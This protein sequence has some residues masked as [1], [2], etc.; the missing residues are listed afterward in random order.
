MVVRI[1]FAKGPSL[2]RRRADR[3][4]VAGAAGAL[5]TPAALVASV[6]AA[7][8]IAADLNV[9]DR[10][11]IPSGLFSHWQ[12]WLGAAVGLQRGQ[13]LRLARAVGVADRAGRRR[14]FGG[15]DGGRAHQPL[16]KAGGGGLSAERVS[17][18]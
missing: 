14:R 18:S 12:V 16:T 13:Q 15:K 4:K 9:T 7:W 6:L 17:T 2:S 5:L 8:R 1:R 10:F 11:A 3:R